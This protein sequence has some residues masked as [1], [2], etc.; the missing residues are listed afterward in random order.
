[1]PKDTSKRPKSARLA[2]KKARFNYEILERIEAGIALKGTE[3]KSLR[4]G[5]A[6][7][8]EAFA[9][10]DRGQVTLHNFQ[11]QPYAQGNRFNHD[12]KRPKQLLLHRREIKRLA[13]K[14]QIKGQTLVPLVVY[15]NERGLAK[16]QLGLAR[17]RTHGDK[18]QDERRRE[19]EREMARATR[20]DQ[21]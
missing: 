9:R 3:V 14:V 15:F 20:R 19:D 12:P 16:V 4:L 6:S 1:M 8:G 11:I 17:G 10:V 5:N 21:L 2:N 18:R 13:S 7:V